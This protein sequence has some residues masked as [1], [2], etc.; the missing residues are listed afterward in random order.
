MRR[1]SA[2]VVIYDGYEEARLAAATLLEYTKG[3]DLE[4]Y[5]VDNHSPDGSGEKL[6]REF[7][8]RATV[9][10]LPENKGFGAGHNVIRDRLDVYKRQVQSCSFRIFLTCSFIIL[11]SSF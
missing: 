7:G 2:S 11:V 1:V 5:L 4:L 10:C 3:V 9:L 8:G 6:E